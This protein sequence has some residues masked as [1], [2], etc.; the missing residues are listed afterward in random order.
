MNNDLKIGSHISI[1]GGY[2][3]AARRAID[4]GARSFQYF[5]KNPRSLHIKDFDSKD[6]QRCKIL[7][8]EAG[9]VSI[10][11]TPYPVNLAVDQSDEQALY[12][13]TVR[14]I[15]NDLCIADA[16]GSLGVVV[17]FGHYKGKDPLQGYKNIIKCLNEVLSSWE[18][19]AKILIENQ[20]GHGHSMG[21]TLEEMVNIRKLSQYPDKI[22]FCFDTCHAFTAGIWDTSHSDS[23]FE[24][25]EV[26]DYWRNLMAVHLNDSR[27]PYGSG[28]DRHARVGEG[29]I[30]EKP[31]QELLTYKG[32]A[33]AAIVME[34]EA[35]IDGTHKE[36]ISKVLRWT[37]L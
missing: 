12:D 13:L 33:N 32:I 4:M 7:C 14:S 28:Q 2:A 11:H 1:R 20:A 9:I 27:F 3:K 6:A 24:K 16:C 37:S 21:T 17:H 10:A 26:L 22:G 15:Q 29:F 30:G 18:G 8:V 25:G 36:D 34:T 19:H 5:P 35:G 23:L 31:F